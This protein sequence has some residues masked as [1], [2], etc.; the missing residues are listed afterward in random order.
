MASSNI[1]FTQSFIE[2]HPTELK[3][4]TSDNETCKFPHR[5]KV[6]VRTN[7]EGY[8]VTLPAG[9]KLISK[10]LKYFIFKV[11][12]G[13][14]S[15][16][17][18]VTSNYNNTPLASA[19][20]KVT[21]TDTDESEVVMTGLSIATLPDKIEYEVGDK[22]DLTGL[23]LKITYSN[24]DYKFISSGF[25]YSSLVAESIGDL[26]IIISYE[27]LEVV[28][29][30]SVKEASEELTLLEVDTKELNIAIGETA[31]IGITTNAS[32]ISATSGRTTIFRVS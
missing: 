15:N 4:H 1:D 24:G 21:V 26:D 32:E 18:I 3:V 17:I 30:V 6:N 5:Y 25:S 19:S 2:V 8:D 27:G 9:Y 13:A 23:V 28:L 12:S 11:R 22:I 10:T 16:E 14:V 20:V 7:D 31:Y 29:G